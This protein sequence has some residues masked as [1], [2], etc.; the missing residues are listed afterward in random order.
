M[1][2]EI[3]HAG[4]GFRGEGVVTH[5]DDE[6]GAGGE[7]VFATAGGEFEDVGLELLTE[8]REFFQSG[9]AFEALELFGEAVARGPP[10]GGVRPAAVG[11]DRRPDVCLASVLF[12]QGGR[13]RA[14]APRF[15]AEK[16]GVGGPGFFPLLKR[17]G[18]IPWT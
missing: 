14:R 9:V 17:P 16:G 4:I 1:A 6:A 18:V 12:Y 5:P 11:G 15:P 13:R 10:H 3:N 8:L 7:T 2:V